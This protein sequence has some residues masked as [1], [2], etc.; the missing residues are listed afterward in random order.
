A[1]ELGSFLTYGAEALAELAEFRS[2]VSLS[3]DDQLR[4]EGTILDGLIAELTRTFRGRVGTFLNSISEG[5]ISMDRE[6]C[7]TYAS[8]GACRIGGVRP[9]D[10]LG[11]SLWRLLPEARGSIFDITSRRAMETQAEQCVEDYYEPHGAWYRCKF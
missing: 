9:E 11:Q 4:H 10:I 3:E 8:E 5:V 7:I 6:W 2:Y 1:G